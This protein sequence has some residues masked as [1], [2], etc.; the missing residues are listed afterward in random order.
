M[1]AGEEKISKATQR[2]PRLA[3]SNLN[4]TQFEFIK[5]IIGMWRTVLAEI[6]NIAR[7]L[8]T[9]RVLWKENTERFCQ[10]GAQCLSVSVELHWYYS[11]LWQSS[12]SNRKNGLQCFDLKFAFM[13]CSYLALLCWIIILRFWPFLLLRLAFAVIALYSWSTVAGP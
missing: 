4:L 7:L 11:I 5:R 9:H 12:W 6:T 3:V 10:N 8:L 2:T 13:V 1:A